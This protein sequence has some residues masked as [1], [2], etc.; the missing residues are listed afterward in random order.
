MGDHCDNKV[1]EGSVESF[2]EYL[3]VCQTPQED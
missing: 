2:K 1:F 3:N